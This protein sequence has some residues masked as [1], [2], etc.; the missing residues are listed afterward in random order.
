V[1]LYMYNLYMYNLDRDM[2]LYMYIL[3][4]YKAVFFPSCFIPW[5]AAAAV[6]SA[7]PHQAA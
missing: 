6:I 1:F 5:D 2:W 4:M 7:E 3:Y